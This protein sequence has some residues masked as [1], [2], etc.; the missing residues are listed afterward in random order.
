MTQRTRKLI[1]TILILVLLIVYPGIATAIYMVW[2]QGQPTWLLLGYFAAAGLLWAVPA[3]VV[4]K[5]MA[6][7]DA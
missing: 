4:I 6:K 2:L 1:G 7:P 5:W 3:G